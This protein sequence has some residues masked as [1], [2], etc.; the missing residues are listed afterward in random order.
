MSVESQ[1]PCSTT[2]VLRLRS[3][4]LTELIVPYQKIKQPNGPWIAHPGLIDEDIDK[5]L[6]R[7]DLPPNATREDHRKLY[8]K[9]LQETLAMI[10]EKNL[11][12]EDFE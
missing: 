4:V 11:K 8:K 7:I 6:A 1:E 3:V 10:K 2:P 5:R 12:F 9:D